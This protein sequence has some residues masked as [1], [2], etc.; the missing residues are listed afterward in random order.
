MIKDDT[1]LV[2]EI[3]VILKQYKYSNEHTTLDLAHLLDN[4]KGNNKGLIN[5]S[6]HN[7]T[8]TY[9]TIDISPKMRYGCQEDANEFIVHLTDRLL[10]KLPKE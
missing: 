7:N 3:S 8:I 5:Q 6:R 1:G 4:L 9:D 2:H 10:Q